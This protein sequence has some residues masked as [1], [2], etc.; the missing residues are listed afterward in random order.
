M[1][2]SGSMMKTETEV[3]RETEIEAEEDTEIRLGWEISYSSAKRQANKLK[4]GSP[5]Q[6]RPHLFL[7]RQANFFVDDSHLFPLRATLV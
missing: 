7:S 3:E 6:G 5:F 4:M 1:E 2:R